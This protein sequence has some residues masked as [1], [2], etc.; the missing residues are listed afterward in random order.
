M[1]KY[2]CIK[3]PSIE[4]FRNVVAA[5]NRKSTFAGL[6]EHG[7]PIYE[8]NR[9]KPTLKFLGSVKLHGSNAGVSLYKGKVQSQSRNNGF[10]LETQQDS[11][12]G[13]TQ[14]VIEREDL[15]RNLLV[16]GLIAANVASSDL[17]VTIF[18]E[19]AGKGIQKGV[20][21]SELEKA[22]Y[23]FGI[24]I[25][26]PGDEDFKS[27]WTDHAFLT[28][29]DGFLPEDSRIFNCLEFQTWTIDIDFNDP[30]RSQNEL[31]EITNKVEEECPV[32]AHF[33]V[34]GIGEGVVWTCDSGRPGS[35]SN[36][37]VFKVKGEKH[38][39]SKVKKLAPVDIEKLNSIQEFVDYAMTRERFE[40]GMAEVFNSPEEYDTKRTGD[41]LRWCVNDIMKEEGDALSGNGLEWKE[42]NK[43]ISSKAREWYFKELELK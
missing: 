9:K 27:F 10:D 28:R 30:A 12:M 31:I 32:A 19:W 34:K 29:V 8:S 24:K 23:I 42:V 26:K 17:A 39:V 33:G 40:Q 20:G 5:V 38:S 35:E 22:F 13:F 43:H 41:I 18:G 4:Q 6:D 11:H 36:R 37:L 7:D 2:K 16:Q 3:F 1:N 14:F 25:S 15:F 21:I